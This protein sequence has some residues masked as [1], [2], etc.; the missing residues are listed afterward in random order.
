LMAVPEEKPVLD[1]P[2]YYGVGYRAQPTPDTANAAKPRA[3][4]HSAGGGGSEPGNSESSSKTLAG[5]G[6]CKL[7]SEESESEAGAASDSESDCD[8]A[9]SHAVPLLP[10]PRINME[11]VKVSCP[12][13]TQAARMSSAQYVYMQQEHQSAAADRLVLCSSR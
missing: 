12:V 2:D 11:P 8:E 7:Q 4:A 9:S 13:R 5:A 3:P 6:A 10:P 1:H